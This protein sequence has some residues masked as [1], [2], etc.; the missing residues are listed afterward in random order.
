MYWRLDAGIAAAM[1]RSLVVGVT[2]VE[3]LEEMELSGVKL[4]WPNEL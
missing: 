1:G 4:K 3:A 2:I